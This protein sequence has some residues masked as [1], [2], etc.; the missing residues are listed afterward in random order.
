MFHVRRD[1]IKMEPDLEIQIEVIQNDESLTEKEKERR[2][3]KLKY[4][5]FKLMMKGKGGIN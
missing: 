3:K 4:K 2:I 1:P 5:Q